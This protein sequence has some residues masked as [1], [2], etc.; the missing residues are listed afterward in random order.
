MKSSRF[1]F[2]GFMCACSALLLLGQSLQGIGDGAPNDAIRFAFQTAF[3][4]GIF[5]NLANLPP[6]GNVKK[7]GTTGL[8][9][10]FADVTQGSSLKHALVLPNAAGTGFSGEIWQ[11]HGPLYDFWTATGVATAG[12]PQSDTQRCPA[13]ITACQ[14]QVF[15]KSHILFVLTSQSSGNTF[16]T[17]GAFF[18]KWNSSGGMNMFGPAISAVET[19]TSG[20]K[21]SATA[22]RQRYLR[23]EIFNWLAGT[24]AGRVYAVYEPIYSYY[25]GANNGATGL[26]GFPTSDETLLS[27]GRRRQTFE[28][29]T[30]EYAQGQEPTILY[31]VTAVILSASSDTLNMKLGDRAEITAAT[32]T[33]TGE[34]VTGRAIS[35]NTSNSRVVAID[36]NGAKATLR[37]VGG[38]SAVV[39]A[40]SEGKVSRSLPVFVSAPCCQAGEGAPSA[41]ISQSFIDAL[42]R[43]RIQVKLPTS[44]PVRRSG[45]GYI[46][47]FTSPDGA[48]RYLLAKPDVLGS[49]F[50]LTG[51]ILTRYLELGGPT[52]TLGYPT[53]DATGGLRQ[54]FEFGALAGSPVQ[55]VVNP[56]L[57]RWAAL[58]FEGGPAGAPTG[59]TE[60]AL[61]FTATASVAQPFAN[62]TFYY[63]TSGSRA[64][65][66]FLV[67]AAMLA[68][69][70][71]DG[72]VSGKL[73]LPIAEESAS[74]G[75]RRQ[76]FEG[77]TL[78]IDAAGVSQINTRPRTPQISA[79][80]AEV[81]A[82]GRVRLAVGGF[83]AGATLRVSVS[84]RPDFLVQSPSGAYAWEML[85]PANTP[86]SLITL[87]AAEV[88]GAALAVGSFVVQAS[89]ETLLSLAKLRGDAQTGLPGAR[90]PQP[91]RISLKD[92]FGSPVS[93]VPV[94]F[95]ASPGA[96]IELADT[97]TDGKGEAQA[98][99]R[100][101]FSE[102]AALATAEA[103]GNVVTFSARAVASSF[104][105]FPNFTQA[106]NGSPL[107]PGPATVADN[108]AL[109]VTAANV[110]RH[111]QNT[112]NLPA[113]NGVADPVLLN[114]FMR[115]I[116][117][118]DSSGAQICDG[119]LVHEGADPTL[120]LWRLGA[121]TGSP[122]QIAPLNATNEAI[123]DTLALGRPVLV[124]L[125]LS[126]NGMPAGA[127]FAAAMGVNATGGILVRDPNPR[128][129]Q[130]TIEAYA[131][132][133]TTP[134]G[135]YKATLAAAFLIEA[136]TVA[137]PSFLLS[138]LDLSLD[139]TGANGRCG[140]TLSWPSHASNGAGLPAAAPVSLVFRSCDGLDAVYQLD[141]TSPSDRTLI[142]TGLGSPP[143]RQGLA[144]NQAA[145]LA[146]TRSSAGWSAGP[147]SVLFTSSA[148][149]NA[150]SFKP[151]LS[152]GALASAFGSGLSSA[153]G[154]TQVEVAGVAAQVLASF[155][156][157]I[158]FVVPPGTP[159][160][161]Q[162]VQISSPY[163][164]STQ[165]VE[166][167]EVSP[168]I[169][170]LASGAPAAVNQSGELNSPS[171]PANRG[172][173]VTIY[174][175]GLGVV[176]R[177]GN[178]DH[179]AA[180]VEATLEGRALTVQFA[181]LAP[182]F[183]GLYQVNLIVPADAP[184][185]LTQQLRLRVAESDAPPIPIAVQ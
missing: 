173:A 176:E 77:G 175:T 129:A 9:Q 126:L 151:E 114:A 139:L 45:L 109:L 145:S 125:N 163:G 85:I 153:A 47:E 91:F 143:S 128:L 110:V 111:L 159:L 62:G 183:S 144:I 133:F 34:Q 120:N 63:A 96:K 119:F 141:A 88:N 168:A 50:V 33:A 24:N 13:V 18:T 54:T 115:D 59:P 101:P 116:C 89:A 167:R 184:P 3:T 148:V 70:R 71:A 92:E 170:L 21:T 82:G 103:G 164:S 106:G 169:F 8:V 122:I 156:F 180:S 140:Q 161:P 22:E 174:A 30:I 130:P 86:N 7:L 74:A 87:R 134:A 65:Q 1:L 79:T 67:H 105:N 44:A 104:T 72:A 36:A 68:A 42:A 35:W 135:L 171:A 83:P 61:S 185:G 27:N 136:Q 49:A 146:V 57:A 32:Y 78:V 152:P 52:G 94:H 23:G 138:A 108:G 124:A 90:L 97:T 53:T 150:A 39:T 56:I 14:Y 117:Q 16:L 29:A 147:L 137:S 127:H 178:L 60:T 149:V 132:G 12:Y 75:V 181:G 17:E 20:A 10:E 15:D 98:Y 46:Q 6:L 154:P 31:P 107:G 55:L 38:G 41:A 80:P 102:T 113:P 155:P 121:F 69:Y 2:A 73:G 123:R 25:V 48:I 28:G 66:V 84:G 162:S 118:F 142:L 5:S 37:A 43:T 158:N 131:T 177:R 157:Q 58:N 93:G 4:R 76:E 26:L 40:V 112:G 95:T 51:A 99:L 81:A 160:G 64:N 19:I 11:V 166:I 172:Q 100:M 165:T 179:V 182:G